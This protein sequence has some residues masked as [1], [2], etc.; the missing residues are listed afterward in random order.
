MRHALAAAS[1]TPLEYLKAL[2]P[3]ISGAAVM[4]IAV[5]L[6]HR[7]LAGLAPATRLAVEIVTGALAYCAIIVLLHGARLRTFVA[8]LRGLR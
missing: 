1:L 3:A 2:W 4:C 6:V 8:T 5:L 7:T